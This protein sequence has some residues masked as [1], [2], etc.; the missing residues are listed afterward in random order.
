[1]APETPLSAIGEDALVQRLLKTLPE[2]AKSVVIGPGD[3]CAVVRLTDGS[4]QLLKTDVVVENVHFLRTAPPEKIGR[5]ALARA[6]SDI[7]AM[8]GKPQHALITLVLPTDLSVEWVE[9]LYEGMRS[10][11][12]PF[13]VSIV[14]GETARGQQLIISVALTGLAT[15][16][17]LLRSGGRP[18][19]RLWVTGTLGGS[20]A[21][22]HFDF[23]P[24][25]VE[26]S[27]LAIRFRPTSM[28]D[29]SDGLAAD[30]PRLAAASN[31]AWQVVDDTLPL[32]NN[33]TI[34]QAWNDGE[35]Y[36]LLFSTPPKVEADLLSAWQ[37]VFP[38]VPL[39]PIGW[40]TEPSNSPPKPLGGWDHFSS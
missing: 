12:E 6:V 5:K 40:L 25:V 39:T 1:M 18:G 9:R 22:H 30:L 23:T 36:E 33:C 28:M 26:A 2:P 14:G 34:R 13:G 21:G 29:L 24:R 3:D 8:G 31:T 20:L 15:H 32:T 16:G 7:A 19:D 17:A 11:A 10:V 37:R 27:W 4:E 35:D 38:R